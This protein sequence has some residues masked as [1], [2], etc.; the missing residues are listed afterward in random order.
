MEERKKKRD[1]INKLMR[2]N[3]REKKKDD[4]SRL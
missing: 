3:D 2:E 1:K 4:V